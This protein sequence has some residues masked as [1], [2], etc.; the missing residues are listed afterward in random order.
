MKS[1]NQ[2]ANA[3][4][5]QQ[6]VS[7]SS[8]TAEQRNKNGPT[9]GEIRRRALRDLRRNEA[10]STGWTWKTGC[11]RN[12]SFGQYKGNETHLKSK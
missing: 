7:G 3:E 2:V 10:E 1:K 5:N 9:S 12:A 8:N 4:R 11:R 6:N